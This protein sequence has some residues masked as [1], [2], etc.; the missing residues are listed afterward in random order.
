MSHAKDLFRVAR[1][2]KQVCKNLA[3]CGEAQ[4][5][6]PLSALGVAAQGF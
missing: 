3:L 6:A 4:V 2:A 5:S 1:Q